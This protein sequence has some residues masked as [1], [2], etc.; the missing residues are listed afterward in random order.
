MFYLIIKRINKT[1]LS[2]K[3]FIFLSRIVCLCLLITIAS[4]G[5]NPEQRI[6]NKYGDT[7]NWSTLQWQRVEKDLL[8]K[9]DANKKER[10]EKLGGINLA[11]FSPSQR[12]ALLKMHYDLQQEEDN[13]LAELETV[14][15]HLGNK[16]NENLEVSNNAADQNGKGATINVTK[17]ESTKA[18]AEVK[19]LTVT[20]GAFTVK[21]PVE[22]NSFSSSESESLQQQYMDQSKQIYE[23]YSG[24]DNPSNSV[25]IAGFH[26]SN[27]GAFIIVTFTIPPHKNLINVLKSQAKEKADWGIQQGYIQKYLGLVPINDH[28]LNGFYIKTIGKSGNVE[29]SGGLEYKKLKNTLIQLTLLCPKDWNQDKATETLIPILNSVALSAK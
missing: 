14:R 27:D 16:G 29:V 23:Q 17:E 22:W 6:K 13:I 7:A 11:D 1:A 26:I 4:C 2:E 10:R 3:T 12:E 21:V 19:F 25:N 15:Q 24:T 5:D 28:N 20:V 8:E 9:L 18:V